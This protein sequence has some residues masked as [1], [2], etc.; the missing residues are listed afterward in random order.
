MA[1]KIKILFLASSP[2]DLGR[3]GLDREHDAI[4]EKLRVGNARD[5]FELIPHFVTRPDRLQEFLLRDQPHVV[6]F[7]GYGNPA[8]EILL[9]DESGGSHPVRKEALTDLFR[10]LKD[11]IR[12]VVLNACYSKAQAE[13]IGQIIDYTIGTN[14]I[15]GDQAAIAFAA[16]FYQGLSFERSVND[17]F[18]LGRN[19]IDMKQ[20]SGSEVLELLVRAGVDAQESF[21]KQ[22]QVLRGDYVEDLK[23]AFGLLG[24]GSATEADAQTIRQAIIAG[25]II[26][27]PDE[28]SD[29][30]ETDVTGHLKVTT[31]RSF[32]DIETDTN[33]FQNVQERLYPSPKGISPPLSRL[34]FVGRAGAL[35]DVKDDL[36][37]KATPP[38]SDRLTVVRGWP[39]VG[40]TSL[41]GVLSRDR[42]VQ[43]AFPDGVLWASLYFGEEELSQSE[44]ESGLLSLMALWGRALGTDALL[45]APTFNEATAQLAELLSKKRMLL[46]VD[47]VWQQGHAVPF[48]QASG[49]ECAVLV[50]TR[51]PEVAVGL[52]AG[53]KKVYKLEPL[54]EEHAFRLLRI[55]AEE[56]VDRH[57]EKCRELVRDLE[58]LP[59]ALHVAAGQLRAEDELGLD[60]ADLIEGIRDG[61]GMLK[62]NAPL[63]RSENGSTPTL[64]ALLRRST[65]GLDEQ[66]RDCFAFLGAFA[67]KP[68]TFDLQA[69]AAVW[70]VSDPKPIVR[71]LVGHGLL[72]PVGKG[73]FQMH[74]L[75]VQHA[76]S[77]LAE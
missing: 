50:T 6:H 58:C 68:A 16:A 64:G 39:G 1:D 67:P 21:V 7:C 38:P 46:I 5:S 72:E 12:I 14:K 24:S 3:I 42:E 19:L 27:Q 65:N 62:A 31:H 32:I 28:I 74:A 54:S 8:E 10:I 69:M 18:A 59:L 76:R 15:I 17:S 11:N 53:R 25:K 60:V 70:E 48:M 36:G 49:S 52:T 26:L 57:P 63:D 75:L 44:Q 34:V 77:L 13:A 30:G 71:V 37:V 73:R 22:Q 41:V 35:H 40:K 47:D 33:T 43:Q 29:G 55:L 4:D 51:L 61:A 23:A 45:R 9:T 20:Q 66:T 2:T 56:I